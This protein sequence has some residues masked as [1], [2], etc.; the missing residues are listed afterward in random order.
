MPTKKRKPRVKNRAKFCY[1][2]T[3]TQEAAVAAARSKQAQRNHAAEL[4]KL[5]PAENPMVALLRAARAGDPEAVLEADLLY[6]SSWR[7]KTRKAVA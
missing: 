6:G 3:K 5:E 7:R 2:I 1:A 4:A